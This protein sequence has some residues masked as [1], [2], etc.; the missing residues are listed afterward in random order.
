MKRARVLVLEDDP[1]WLKTIHDVLAPVSGCLIGASTIS[2]AHLLLQK[3]YFNVAVVDLSLKL[4]DPKDNQGMQFLE[5]LERLG[6][7]EAVRCIILSAYGDVGR[8]RDAFRKFHVV[9]FLEKAPFEAENLNNA[10][11]RALA[12]NYLYQR[13]LAI[14]FVDGSSLEQLWARFNWTFR[15]DSGQL[16]PEFYDLLYRL[17][18]Q[19]EQLDLSDLP[20]G[21]SG[22][23]VLRVDR[24]YEARAGTPVVIKIGKRDKIRQEWENYKEFVDNYANAFS[25][26]QLRAVPGRLMGA[27]SYQLIGTTLDGVVSFGEYYHQHEVGQVCQ[28][29]DGLFRETCGRWYDNREQP[30]RRRDLIQLYVEGLHLEWDEVWDHATALGVDLAAATLQFPGLSGTFANPKRWLESRDYALYLPVWRAITHGDLNENNIRVTDEGRCWL[31]DFYRTGWG[32]IL[33]DVVELETAIKFNLTPMNSLE[34]FHAFEAQLLGQTQIGQP[35]MPSAS[36]SH[37]KPLA[38]IG[39]L[40]GLAD[41]FTGSNQDMLEYNIGLLLTTLNLL[42]F[43]FMGEHHWRILLSAAMLCQHLG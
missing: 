25:S 40:R 5:M 37:F 1:H 9:D 43:D 19:A 32:H 26:V 7:L 28:A 36:H 11:C 3:H 16:T 24:Y 10:V 17:F 29:L 12:A 35:V 39:H 22:A 30:R 34:E 13:D 33:R 31:I 38:V 41:P 21:Q 8:V 2:E 42:R 15:E 4:G 27:L 20:T 18:N 14:N 6:L 23:A